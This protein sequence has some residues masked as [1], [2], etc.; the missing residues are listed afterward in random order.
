MPAVYSIPGE[1]EHQDMTGFGR[2]ITEFIPGVMAETVYPQMPHS[3]KLQFVR[4]MALAWRGV[5]DLP[6]PSPPRIGELIA[7]DIDG[8]VCVSVGPDR[9]YSLG[10]PYTS[11][12][13]W[14][15]ARILCAVD[16]L[17]RTEG[18]DDYKEEYM[19][20]IQTFVGTRLDQI[21]E[22]VEECPIT[23]LHVDMG[24]H[25]VIV[26]A[27]DHKDI[28]AIIDWEFSDS[29]PFLAAYECLD[30]LFRYGGPNGFGTEYAQADELRSAFW[31]S[32]PEWE[33]HWESQGVKDF[34]EWFRFALFLQPRYADKNLS[35]AG[36]KEFWAEN[37]RVVEGMVKKYGEPES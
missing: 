26:S 31:E 13:E 22:T 35:K 32:I 29:A 16:S 8:V 30:M 27:D 19:V 5:W 15:K 34:M 7:E 28:K 12:R 17:D 14:L 11:V 6:L 21:P 24:L 9:H 4:K 23:A 2:Q 20:P 37:I 10:G 33:A 25:N 1:A 36:Q 18:I 3:D